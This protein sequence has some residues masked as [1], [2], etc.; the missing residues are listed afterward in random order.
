MAA[1]RTIGVVQARMG[2]TRLPGKVLRTLRGEPALVHVWRRLERCRGLDAIWLAT[3]DRPRDDAIAALA[4]RRGWRLHR[5]SEHDVLGRLLGV[6]RR[7]SADVLV[8]VCAD[9]PALDPR[10]V[11]LG[12]RERAARRLDV[13]SSFLPSCRLPFGA[14]AEVGSRA[15]LERIDAATEDGP[16]RYREHVFLYATER[17]TAFRLGVPPAPPG[18]DRPDVRISVDTAADFRRMRALYARLP[19][20]STSLADTI[21]AWDAVSPELEEVHPCS[22]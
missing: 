18:L 13:C 2:S 16:A 12:I 11:E 5:G 19:E 15:C 1:A 9:N 7:E 10:T 17:P 3:S 8:R 6:M 20:G 22:R 4:A 14:G 21:A